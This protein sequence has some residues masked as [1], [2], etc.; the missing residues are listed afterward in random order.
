MILFNDNTKSIIEDIIIK[1]VPDRIDKI[2]HVN[3]REEMKVLVYY[4]ISE[5]V[6]PLNRKSITL[7]CKEWKTLLY[8]KYSQFN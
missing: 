6:L 4:L 5:G 2:L 3:P 8:K 7:I 1:N